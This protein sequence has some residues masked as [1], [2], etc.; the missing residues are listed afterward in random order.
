MKTCVITFMIF[1]NAHLNEQ[2]KCLL[3]KRQKIPTLKPW[4]WDGFRVIT[5]LLYC[6]Y[7]VNIYNWHEAEANVHLAESLLKISED[8]VSLFTFIQSPPRQVSIQY[9]INNW[10]NWKDKK[11]KNQVRTHL[12]IISLKEKCDLT[13]NRNEKWEKWCTALK[14]TSVKLTSLKTNV[15]T[16]KCFRWSCWFSSTRAVSNIHPAVGRAHSQEGFQ[17]SCIYTQE[18]GVLTSYLNLYYLCFKDWN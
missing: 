8:K 4:R 17:S 1:L 18:T 6:K 10:C 13:Q 9:F 3:C 16:T 7:I 14:A 15:G 12:H 2:L 5:S 11:S